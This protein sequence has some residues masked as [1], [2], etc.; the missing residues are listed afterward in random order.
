MHTS[1]SLEVSSPVQNVEQRDVNERV[2]LTLPIPGKVS[3][4]AL[5]HLT[6]HSPFGFPNPHQGVTLLSIFG[7]LF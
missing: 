4:R 1:C 7:T 2:S 3:Y 6:F 5:A